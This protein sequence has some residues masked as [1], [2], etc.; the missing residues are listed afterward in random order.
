M[1]RS[2]RNLFASLLVVFFLTIA[3]GAVNRAL[4]SQESEAMIPKLPEAEQ[5]VNPLLQPMGHGKLTWFFIDVYYA[6]LWV[7]NGRNWS[8]DAPFALGLHYLRS[9]E[10][11]DLVTTTLSEMERQASESGALSNLSPKDMKNWARKLE[12]IFPSVAIGDEIVAYY[13]PKEDVTRFYHNGQ[14]RG[15]IAGRDFAERFFDIWLGELTQ[16][17]NLRETLLQGS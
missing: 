17:P 15:E 8:L 6:K 13:L 4:A 10:G 11:K 16:V 3:Y 7:E 1:M 12:E 9:I 2:R 14:K 5:Q